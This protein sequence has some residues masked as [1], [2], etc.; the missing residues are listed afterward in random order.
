[1]FRDPLLEFVGNPHLAPGRLLDRQRDHCRFDLR[2]DTILKDWLLPAELGK[3]QLAAVIQL[4]EP[5]EAVAT[6]FV[7]GPFRSNSEVGARSRSGSY[8][9]DFLVWSFS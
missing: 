6:L 3:R 4:L 1:V 2:R 8:R 7:A 9:W 5:V